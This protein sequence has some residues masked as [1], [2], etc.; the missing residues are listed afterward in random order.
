[1]NTTPTVSQ[2][3]QSAYATG[4]TAA[5]V[6]LQSQVAELANILKELVESHE[7]VKLAALEREN[8]LNKKL[9]E[10]KIQVNDIANGVGQ[11]VVSN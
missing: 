8:G 11:R 6:K 1:M 5:S 7:N 9:S 3:A 2:T 10:L 4:E